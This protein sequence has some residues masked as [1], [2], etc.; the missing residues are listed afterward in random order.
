MAKGD[1]IESTLSLEKAGDLAIETLCK[2]ISIQSFSKEEGKVV[3]VIEKVLIDFGYAFQK[4]GNNVWAKCKDFSTDRPT[5]LLNSHL[6]TV[7]PA[8]GWLT[9]PFEPIIIDGKLTGLGSNDAGGSLVSLLMTFLLSEKMELNY[10]R[11]FLASVEEEISGK[12]G[13]EYV[14]PELG[15]ID[16]G[17]VGEPT[18]MEMA[19][20]EKGLMVLDCEVYGKSG[21]AARTGGINAITEAIKEIE[22][23]HTFKFPKDSELLGP[24]KMTVT[25]IN[26]GT[27]HNVIPDKCTFVVD[28]RTNEHYLNKEAL[29][30]IEKGTK[31]KV[32]PRSTRMNSSG[33]DENHPMVLAA[34]KLN[35]KRFASPTTSDQALMTTFPT[36]KMGPGDSNRSH[37]AN[38]YI[39]LDEIKS[40]I[41]IYCDLL[42]EINF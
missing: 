18:Q 38:E 33:I 15:K 23:F 21:H 41:A 3:L 10:N 29:E 39:Y 8:D 27:Q 19:V 1:N 16:V 5:L 31:A 22:W 36:V 4:K 42:K 14:L 28:V 7:K 37:T 9:N 11:I 2:L 30:I 17:I 26:S 32:T 34:K 6:D 25:L 12:M 40:G 24:V 35:I 13:M 20:A